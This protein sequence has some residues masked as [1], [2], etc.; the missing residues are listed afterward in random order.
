M[1]TPADT[2]SRPERRHADWTYLLLSITLVPREWAS[3]G[4]VTR[5]L[6]NMTLRG[7]ESGLRDE[8]VRFFNAC[9]GQLLCHLM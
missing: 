9:F 2:E 4:D 1:Y 8:T 5:A 7:L 6:L 3:R